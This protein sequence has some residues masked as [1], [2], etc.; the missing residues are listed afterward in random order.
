MPRRMLTTPLR[1]VPRATTLEVATTVI[2]PT[3]EA[4]LSGKPSAALR[5]GTR[6]TPPP[7]P[8]IEPRPPAAAP[9]AITM[10]MT[11]GDISGNESQRQH[12]SD[13]DRKSTRLNS[14]HGY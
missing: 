12:G 9:A 6:N 3:P 13:E 4:M 1:L 11:A 5:K 14:S 8:S 7:S 10:A 2:S